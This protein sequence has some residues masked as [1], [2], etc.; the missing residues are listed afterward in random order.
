MKK[1]AASGGRKY[2]LFFVNTIWLFDQYFY[3]TVLSRC[4]ITIE[5]NARPK[6]LGYQVDVDEKS[7]KNTFTPTAYIIPTILFV[8]Y[9]LFVCLF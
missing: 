8:I 5:P 4:T 9:P 7:F 6:I 2:F 3:G 1:S